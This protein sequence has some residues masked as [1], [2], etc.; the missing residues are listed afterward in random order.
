[1]PHIYKPQSDNCSK[2]SLKL[3]QLF[4]IRLILKNPTL[5]VKGASVPFFLNTLY[6]SGV[7]MDF[8]S[9]SV[10]KTSGIF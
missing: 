5:P 6:A 7:R 2:T 9:S 10:L 3:L 8:H 4:C 1:M